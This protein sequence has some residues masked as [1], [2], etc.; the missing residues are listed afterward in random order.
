MASVKDIIGIS[1]HEAAQLREAGVRTCEQLIEAGVTSSERMHLADITHLDD[2]SIK[3]W[4]HQADL[5]RIR[6]V[7]PELARLL[8]LVGVCTVPKLA[9]RNSESLYHELSVYA[10]RIQ[11]ATALPSLV[12]LHNFGVLARQLPKLV[13]H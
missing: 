2:A 7:G 4:V 13:R 10:K 12:E 8:C 6:G 9:Y 5:M 11:D 1:E 3:S